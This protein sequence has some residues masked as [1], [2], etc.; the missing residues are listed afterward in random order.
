MR[1]L[2]ATK[3]ALGCIFGALAVPVII[4][5]VF[6]GY[7][8]ISSIFWPADPNERVAQCAQQKQYFQRSTV[9][10]PVYEIGEAFLKEP[11]Y[12]YVCSR[13][14]VLQKIQSHSNLFKFNLNKCSNEDATKFSEYI[15]ENF[16]RNEVAVFQC[17]KH[18]DGDDLIPPVQKKYDAFLACRSYQRFTQ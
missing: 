12:K 5:A 3:E 10:E 2:R 7:L 8:K 14:E 15:V 1:A 4:I 11:D 6:V 9:C 18:F 16:S 13:T 17:A